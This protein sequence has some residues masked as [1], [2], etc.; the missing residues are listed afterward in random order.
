[1]KISE[2]RYQTYEAFETLSLSQGSYCGASFSWDV[3]QEE[4]KCLCYTNTT[5]KAVIRKQFGDLRFKETWRQAA[6]HYSALCM[7]KSFLEPYQLVCYIALPEQMSDP[8]RDAYGPEVIEKVLSYPEVAAK[9]RA[10]LEQL[11]Q[12]LPDVARDFVRTYESR[13][14]TDV[15]EALGSTSELLLAA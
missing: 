10:G 12:D 4:Q 3:P 1:M 9:I 7:V 5:F 11:F 8:V 14:P 13:M 15:C 6:I 2:L